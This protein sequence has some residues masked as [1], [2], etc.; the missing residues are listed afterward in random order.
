MNVELASRCRSSCSP[1]H[2]GRPPS[3]SM[4]GASAFRF[5]L[6]QSLDHSVSHKITQRHTVLFT[7]IFNGSYSVVNRYTG[8]P[9]NGVTHTPT[10]N[11]TRNYPGQATNVLSFAD[12]LI[13]AKAWNFA[14]EVNQFNS[15]FL[16]VQGKRTHS[17]YESKNFSPGERF[18]HRSGLAAEHGC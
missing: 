15:L 18:G 3:G 8:I 1:S 2:R 5:S 17:R 4:H 11:N 7:S 14:T 6:G 16:S 10:R 9:R 13:W 12:G